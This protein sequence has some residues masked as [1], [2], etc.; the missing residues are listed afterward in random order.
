MED[1]ESI[2][3]RVRSAADAN[4]IEWLRAQLSAVLPDLEK[5]TVPPAPELPHA[6]RSRP[7]PVR[8]SP[9]LP[10][11]GRR[12]PGSPVLDPSAPTAKRTPAL[13]SGGAGRNSLHRRTPGEEC[14]SPPSSSTPS[15]DQRDH[16]AY[17]AGVLPA[18]GAAWRGRESSTSADQ[19]PGATGTATE[20][21]RG[22]TGGGAG[23]ATPKWD[24]H[25][26]SATQS[27]QTEQRGRRAVASDFFSPQPSEEDRS[28]EALTTSEDGAE[29]A[30]D[31]FS[32][33][34]LEEDRAEGALTTS[35]G[36]SDVFSRQPLEEDRSEEALT[37][38]E[39]GAEAAS[40]VFTRQPWEEDRAEGAL[41][42][43]EGASDVFTRQP[44]EEDRSEGELTT[45]EDGEEAASDVFSRQPWEE[46]RA[47]GK[48]TTLEE[49][50]MDAR[51][52]FS[53]RQMHGQHARGLPWEEERSED[54]WRNPLPGSDTGLQGSV[55]AT[56]RSGVAG[57]PGSECL[58]W[59]LGHN[60]V[61]L[62][63]AHA[64]LNPDGLQLGFPREQ[65]RIKWIGVPGMLWSRVL[66]E[67]NHYSRLDRPPDVLLLHV[68][69]NDLGVRPLHELSRDI[70][71]DFLHLRSSF[72]KTV[73]VW[74]DIVARTSWK[75]AT[76]VA[77]LNKA[78]IKINKG[79][80]RFFV[81]NGGLAIRHGDMEKEHRLFLREDGVHL[82]SVGIDLW[83][84]GLQ[85]GIER[86]FRVW[87]GAQA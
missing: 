25:A 44:W 56:V 60:Y 78:R 42:T 69:G 24:W 20:R 2:L 76:S 49:G 30:S 28:E 65:V 61:V 6:E 53:R 19:I 13:W 72:P 22:T 9:E 41:T 79:M 82:N 5:M 45:S 86:A 7:P 14:G 62:G 71:S 64:G 10:P 23:A 11:R 54:A 36:A 27:Q 18:A 4:G 81:H 74:S 32:R 59:I 57:Q 46:D 35:E 34:P 50:A 48:L 3:A 38:S 47:E 17:P 37:T 83:C 66:P 33:Q 68:G 75:L 16:V 70:K 39:D 1:V 87:R 63:A 77:R 84:L 51:D 52:V 67:V 40:D 55:S 12:R 26:A 31:V 29:A 43:S 73:V 85:E 21:S 15:A 80:A 58:V 8:S